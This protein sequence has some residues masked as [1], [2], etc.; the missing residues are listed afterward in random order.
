M[1][2]VSASPASTAARA[3]APAKTVQ[4]SFYVDPAEWHA[5]QLAA[6]AEGVTASEILRRAIRA[7]L[8]VR[9]QT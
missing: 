1:P 5:V 6:L 9:D 8:D 2:P 3:A 4:R 7:A